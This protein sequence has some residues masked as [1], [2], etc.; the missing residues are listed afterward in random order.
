MS[1]LS[2]VD[3]L[4]KHLNVNAKTICWGLWAQGIPA[5]KVGRSWR[6][7]KKDLS[8]LKK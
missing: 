3:E 1:G 5:F 6:I 7:A 2:T 8:W 4:A